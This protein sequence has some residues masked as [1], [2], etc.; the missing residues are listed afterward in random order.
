MT[1]FSL[2]TSLDFTPFS[3]VWLKYS[4]GKAGP[5]SPR[6]PSLQ[7]GTI[8]LHSRHRCWPTRLQGKELHDRADGGM[9]AA[10]QPF[11]LESAVR[12]QGRTEGTS[13]WVAGSG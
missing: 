2:C 7:P 11:F 10:G 13:S 6:W 8:P 9:V 3:P 12:V 5:R 4:Q 1:L